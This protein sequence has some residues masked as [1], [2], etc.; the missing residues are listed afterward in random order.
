MIPK[1]AI[2]NYLSRRL[3]D[4][5]ILK[6]KTADELQ[7]FADRLPVEP[8]LWS[9]LR[10]HQKV[11]VILGA[12]L[13]RFT[14]LCDTGT[15]KTLISIV[16][17]RYFI[18]LRICS[19]FIVLVPNKINTYEWAR[20]IAKHSPETAYCVLD[21]S[22]QEK[23]DI[24]NDPEN[25]ARLVLTTY[26]G[27]ARMVTE[28]VWDEESGRNK[29]VFNEA[30]VRQFISQFDG[31][32]M[33]ESH[34]VK[35]RG[36]LFH[37]LCRKMSVAYEVVFGLT[38]TP[39]GRDPGDL[40]AQYYVVDHG[41]TLGK[42]LGL[43]RAAF[44]KEKQTRY[45]IEYKFNKKQSAAINRMLAHRAIRYAAN[46]ADLPR[47]VPV[48][49]YVALPHTAREYY[50]AARQNVIDAGGRYREMKNAF[51]RM[52]QI[53]SGFVG[54]FDDEIGARAEYVFD[55]NPKLEM[56]TS[57]VETIP[58]PRKIVIYHDFIMSGKLIAR[59]LDDLGVGYTTV[60]GAAR[61]TQGALHRFDN[62]PR[63]Q[64]LVLSNA[65]AIGLNLQVAQYGIFYESPVPVITRKQAVRRIERQESQHEVVFIYDLIVR[66][67]VD[68]QILQFHREGGDLFQA[69]VE[70]QVPR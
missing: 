59:A 2:Q 58:Q 8:P 29:L 50:L 3:R 36:S 61:D 25:H 68:E 44:F 10:L 28:L 64:V 34:R 12:W 22:T 55:V 17:A 57:I 38:G 54:Y 15:G 42:T 53:S 40:W 26:M 52:R 48:Y 63:C 13:R 43:F 66:D 35:S 9:K 41:E 51:M 47:L 16:L 18:R 6:S 30:L 21:G 5:R 65:M 62:D 23:W 49:K 7:E 14:F 37:K 32:F 27:A 19:R 1:R 4:C 33:D 70:G 11:C 56:L 24:L 60:S 45:G 20:E 31:L 69:I 39:F 67:T 46:A